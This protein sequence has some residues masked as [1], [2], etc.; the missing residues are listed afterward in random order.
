MK[1]VYTDFLLHFNDD[2][3]DNLLQDAVELLIKW[4]FSLII[5]FLLI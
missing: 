4:I 5:I 3:D 2:F 1:E